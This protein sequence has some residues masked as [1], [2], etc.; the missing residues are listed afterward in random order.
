MV[1]KL[2]L[3]LLAL[4]L[5]VAA[6]IAVARFALPQ[7]VPAGSENTTANIATAMPEYRPRVVPE[8]LDIAKKMTIDRLTYLQKLTQDEWLVE[9]RIYIHR[10]PPENI[11]DAIAKVQERLGD[12]NRMSHAEWIQEK[13]RLQQRADREAAKFAPPSPAK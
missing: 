9:R 11:T 3:L 8:T 6:A 4:T 13:K 10:N 5:P 12:L 2:V 1:K 7:M